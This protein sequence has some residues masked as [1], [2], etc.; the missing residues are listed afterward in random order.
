[1]QSNIKSKY[2]RKAIMV[3][4]FPL[5]LPLCFLSY[6]LIKKEIQEHFFYGQI[7]KAEI[8]NIEDFT[9]TSFPGG[10]PPKYNLTMRNLDN[11]NEITDGF[12]VN[13]GIDDNL[14]EFIN[15]VEVNDTVEVKILNK[16]QAKILKFKGQEV[17][18][19]NSYFNLF[20]YYLFILFLLGLIALPYY[21]YFKYKK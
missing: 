2:R 1:M 18:P 21:V 12:V 14:R 5:S 9:S 17:Q 16:N 15:Q 20:W 4:F 7:V 3:I 11:E 19:Y 10:G 8:R 6:L 13:D